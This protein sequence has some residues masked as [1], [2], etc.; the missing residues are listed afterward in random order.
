MSEENYLE[1]IYVDQEYNYLFNEEN[2]DNKVRD[3][4]SIFVIA[5]K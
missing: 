2:L 1:T 3:S 4:D 5:I